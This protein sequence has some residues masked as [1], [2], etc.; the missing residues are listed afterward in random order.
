MKNK[1]PS[2][3]EEGPKYVEFGRAL[4]AAMNANGTKSAD[5]AQELQVSAESVRLWR[6]GISMPRDKRLKTLAAM[7]G[8]D[9]AVLR[10]GAAVT[11]QGLPALAGEHVTDDD[12]IALLHAYRGLRSSWARRA[13]RARALQLLQEFGEPGV[14]NP[15]GR[16]PRRS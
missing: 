12:E 5:V 1:K 6:A 14:E 9:P 7:V 15:F 4:C 16:A 11:R 13:L 8:V 2:G 3:P 10:Y